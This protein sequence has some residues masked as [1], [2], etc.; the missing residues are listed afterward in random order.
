MEPIRVG[1]IGGGAGAFIGA[2][3]RRAM[4]LSGGF[5]LV[6]GCFSRDPANTRETGTEQSLLPTLGTGQGLW[7]IKHRSFV[8]QHQ[9]HPAELELF[10]TTG[11]MNATAPPGHLAGE[12]T[13]EGGQ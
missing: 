11:R 9:L 13:T 5:A 2:V 8:V 7:R 1:M 6:A 10:D 12:A 4:G 3:H